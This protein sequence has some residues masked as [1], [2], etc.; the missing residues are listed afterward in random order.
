[1]EDRIIEG[2]VIGAS[3]GALAGVTVYVIQYFHQKVLDCVESKKLRSWLKENSSDKNWRST[4]TIASWNNLPVELVQ[5]LCSRD[6]KIK[7]STGE[8]DGLW[9][10]RDNVREDLYE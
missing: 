1:M 3:G 9:A 8:N 4:R 7:L 5:Y 6:G 10:H 2:V